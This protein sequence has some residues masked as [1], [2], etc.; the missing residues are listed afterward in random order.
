LRIDRNRKLTLRRRSSS[1][2]PA[3]TFLVPS[4]DSIRL[5]SAWKAAGKSAELHI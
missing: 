3:M 1:G 4:G 5:Y 2:V